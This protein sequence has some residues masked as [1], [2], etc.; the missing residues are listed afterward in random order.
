MRNQ[1]NTLRQIFLV[2]ILVLFQPTS[3]CAFSKQ[4]GDSGWFRGKSYNVKVSAIYVSRDERSLVVI[5]PDYHYIFDAPE[6]LI[7]STAEPLHQYV[8]GNFRNFLVRTNGNISGDYALVLEKRKTPPQQFKAAMAIGY[9]QA[10]NQSLFVLSGTLKGKRYAASNIESAL[11]AVSLNQTYNIRVEEDKSTS[12]KV[13]DI[14]LSPVYVAAGGVLI[15]GSV[16]LTPLAF[17][18]QCMIGCK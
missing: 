6:A 11:P 7:K 9:R 4:P 13:A 14:L 2:S 1:N 17:I 16:V 10:T 8:F 12:G 5:T 3:G 15:I 18:V